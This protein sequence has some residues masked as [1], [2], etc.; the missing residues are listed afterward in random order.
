MDIE[1]RVTKSNGQSQSA[2]S[3]ISRFS[4]AY[5]LMDT[6]VD[7]RETSYDGEYVI[8]IQPTRDIALKKIEL[9][10][11]FDVRGAY[12]FDNGSTG[13]SKAGILSADVAVPFS[14]D[15]FMAANCDTETEGKFFFLNL[16]F[17]SFERFF[18]YFTYSPGCVTAVYDL[19]SRTISAGTIMRLESIMIN[20]TVCATLFLESVAESIAQKQKIKAPK[21]ETVCWSAN[22][23]MPG[24]APCDPDTPAV[25]DGLYELTRAAGSDGTGLVRKFMIIDGGWQTGGDFSCELSADASIFPDGINAVAEQN[26]ENGFGT[27]ISYSP[28]LISEDSVHFKDYSY[29]LY[30]DRNPVPSFSN[31][32]PMN[33]ASQDVQT[34]T[35]GFIK[36]IAGQ[37]GVRAVKLDRLDALLVRDDDRFSRVIYQKDYSVALLRN[38]LKGIRRAA[39]D[40]VFLLGD[41]P[42]GECAGV[43]DGVVIS[44]DHN[45]SAVLSMIYRSFYNA[46]LFRTFSLGGTFYGAE[47]GPDNAFSEEEAML[48]LIAAAFSGGAIVLGGR[49]DRYPKQV[50]SLI[51]GILPPCGIVSRPVD[52]WEYPYCTHTVAQI[53][54]KSVKTEIHVLYNFDDFEEQR[55]LKVTEPSIF[56]DMLSGKLIASGR[57]YVSIG[58][59][60]HS[61]FPVLVK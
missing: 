14:R 16:G 53:P 23:G 4:D 6:V 29:R 15:V 46:S 51:S 59:K 24:A 61:A 38:L 50:S 36:T 5:M 60:P 28:A 11:R 33:P 52:F 42:A 41:G 47:D 34:E 32:Y 17:T 44:D 31:I 7:I 18:T 19:E 8:F 2:V 25:P 49:S 40:N 26:S 57:A 43:L 21:P 10:I 45:I 20:D 54:D 58:I 3:D 39:G 27:G 35:Y 37:W 9:S 12:V 30:S 48:S 55:M 13:R 1:I 22:R 56:V